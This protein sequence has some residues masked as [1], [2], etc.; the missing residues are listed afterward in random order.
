M[1]FL[2]IL[3]EKQIL[4]LSND[5]NLE[6]FKLLKKDILSG[7][8][9]PAVRKNQIYFYYEGGCLYKFANGK[10]ARDKAFEKY[11]CKAENLSPYE[12]A[13]LQVKNKF[14]NINGNDKERRLL[15]SLYSHTFGTEHQFNT[16]VLDIEINFNGNIVRGKKCDIVLYNVPQRA[17]MFVEGKIF[18]DSR[19]NVKCGS[20]PEV[21]EQVNLYSSA[22][23]EQTE[24][25]ICQYANYIKIINRL[26]GTNYPM[27]QKLIQPAKLLVYET[28]LNL[29]ENNLYSINTITAA[30]GTNN[31]VWFK[32]NE[33]PS[34]DEI[35]N[36]LCK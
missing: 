13:K 26:F 9:F 22:I 36:S 34:T 8:V 33:R 11:S 25:I 24:T 5:K 16:I 3:D 7:V 6:L 17:L 4:A 18:F 29:T 23:D 32:Q 21:I 15:N 1:S 28:P 14:T 35:W 12:T 10:F 2:R 30:L 19:V 27:P 20:V 31:T